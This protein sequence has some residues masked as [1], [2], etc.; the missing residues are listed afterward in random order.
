MA[1]DL[2]QLRW[3]A[4]C[5]TL[6][7][8][9]R[10]I[11]VSLVDPTAQ[12]LLA[13]SRTRR[14]YL[15]ETDSSLFSF[16]A[17][18]IANHKYL[19]KLLLQ[20]AGLP[21]PPGRRFDRTQLGDAL[22]YAQAVGGSV[23]LKPC[24]AGSGAGVHIGLQTF[25][26][27]ELAFER[28]IRKLGPTV[29]ILVERQVAGYEFRIFIATDG[30]YAVIHRDPAHVIGN[31]A[32]TIEALAEAESS[33]RTSPRRNCLAPIP[34][35]DTV[36]RYLAR[37]GRS[38][39][40]IPGPGEKVYLRAN[41]NVNAGGTAEDW[42]DRV[43]PSVIDLAARALSAVPGLPYVGVDFMTADVT[44]PQADVE[45]HLIELNTNPSIGL[46]RSPGK[47]VG[48]DVAGVMADLLFPETRSGRVPTGPEAIP[49]A[50]TV[51][52]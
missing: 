45:H 27:I 39:Q 31:G 15:L 28:I 52:R 43:H 13:K 9:A 46:H 20:D 30:R 50:S 22:A 33:R 38:L 12:L 5:L 40:D 10:G 2:D 35:D 34:L 24:T 21:V 14:E 3:N 49:P 23:V 36:R 44:V 26:E 19:S 18:T 16:S 47:G 4:R 25:T 48:R 42:T 32:D 7:L 51:G 6:E 37:T 17:G 1:E 41:S 11:E 29:E 8:R